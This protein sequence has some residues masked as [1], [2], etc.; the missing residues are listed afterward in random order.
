VRAAHG[1][2]AGWQ[3]DTVAAAAITLATLNFEN[4]SHE[5]SPE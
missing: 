3:S 2:P 5:K 1:Q 4:P